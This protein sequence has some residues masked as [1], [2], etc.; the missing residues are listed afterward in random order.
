[1]FEAHV[2]VKYKGV[3]SAEADAG[4]K[5]S[6]EY[7]EYNEVINKNCSCKGG[8]ADSARQIEGAPEDGKTGDWRSQWLSSLGKNPHV[9]SLAVQTLWE[10]MT[11]SEDDKVAALSNQV[12]AAYDWFCQN[13]QK[14][15]TAGLMTVT[16]DWGSFCLLNPSATLKLNDG[17]SEDIKKSISTSPT[18]IG[19]SG[20]GNGVLGL[21]IG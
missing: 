12:A 5:N 3:G 8:D 1:M 13:P 21:G 6:S 18:S 16:S 14:H 20:M 10:V 19:W 4:V 7:K 9:L 11:A 2:Q 17:L 15:I